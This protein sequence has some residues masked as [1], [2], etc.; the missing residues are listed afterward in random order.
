MVARIRPQSSPFL[1]WLI[2]RHALR[3]GLPITVARQHVAAVAVSARAREDL[4]AVPSP[5]TNAVNGT[6]GRRYRYS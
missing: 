4:D 5:M 6:R 1:L 3:T 2:R